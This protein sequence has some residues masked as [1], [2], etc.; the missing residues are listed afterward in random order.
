M[1]KCFVKITY[2]K[3]ASIVQLCSIPFSNLR[4]LLNR[5]KLK[6]HAFDI[7]SAELYLV[8]NAIEA[9]E[10]GDTISLTTHASVVR[11]TVLGVE[12]VVQDSGPGLPL[13][14][15][16]RLWEPKRSAKGGDHQGLGL[17]LVYR[18]VGALQG[19]IDV[20]TPAETGTA[21]SLFLPVA[22]PEGAVTG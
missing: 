16:Q 22:V 8:K 20:R 21:F 10:A 11:D 6:S 3:H 15:L 9:C 12:V 4:K 19:H 7:T 5:N 18:L 1:F 2:L 14:V 13:P 17:H